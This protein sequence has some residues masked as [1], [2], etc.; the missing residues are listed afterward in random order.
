MDMETTPVNLRLF[1]YSTFSFGI[2][3]SAF[4]RIFM[5]QLFYLL[6]VNRFHGCADSDIV[7]CCASMFE[8]LILQKVFSLSTISMAS[9]R[10]IETVL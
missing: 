8:L 9:S 1:Y 3:V 5:A 2:I 6:S 10:A 4:P 7:A